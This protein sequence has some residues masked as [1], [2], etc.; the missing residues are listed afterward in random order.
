MV[1]HYSK[2]W[3]R[4]I[5][6]PSRTASTGRTRSTKFACILQGGSKG[7]LGKLQQ[8]QIVWWQSCTWE[9]TGS[10][11]AK[12]LTGVYCSLPWA[13]KTQWTDNGQIHISWVR[14][15]FLLFA[16]P[17]AFPE[18]GPLVPLGCTVGSAE[19]VMFDMFGDFF[20]GGMICSWWVGIQRRISPAVAPPKQPAIDQHDPGSWRTGGCEGPAGAILTSCFANEMGD[21]AVNKPPSIK[22]KPPIYVNVVAAYW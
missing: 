16:S 14:F 20:F 21:L 8:T 11:F 1:L 15:R 17:L 6:S 5:S 2:F 4:L 12:W 7:E 19:M 18:M 13:G 3:H 10:P 22:G 9:G